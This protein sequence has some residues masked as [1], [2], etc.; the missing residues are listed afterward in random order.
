MLSFSPTNTFIKVDL[1][2]LGQPTM[3]T[4][5]DLCGFCDKL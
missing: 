4:K 3:L 5:P 2:T 1:P